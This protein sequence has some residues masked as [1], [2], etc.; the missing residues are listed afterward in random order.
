MDDVELAGICTG[1]G[2]YCSAVRWLSLHTLSQ[3][4]LGLC[5]QVWVSAAVV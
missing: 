3:C 4:A 5:R 2:Y 1:S